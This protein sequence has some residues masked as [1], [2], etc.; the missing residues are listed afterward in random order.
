MKKYFII[1]FLVFV[2]TY[3]IIPHSVLA[4]VFPFTGPLVPCGT[5]STHPCTLCDIFVLLR[6]VINLFLTLIIFIAPILIIFGGIMLLTSAGRPEGISYGKRIITNA[7]I[8]IVLAFGAWVIINTVMVALVGENPK[9]GFP[10]PWNEIPCKSAG[11]PPVG[12]PTKGLWG[13]RPAPSGSENW[14]L[15]GIDS[16]Q[17]G[18]ASPQL[19]SFLNCMYDQYSQLGEK[20]TLMIT[21]ISSDILVKNPNCDTTGP[22]CGHHANSCHY[23]GTKCTGY[24][25]AVD[26]A[27]NVPCNV[28]QE[29]AQNCYPS[30]WINWEGNH[31]HVSVGHNNCGCNEAEKGNP[32]PS[33]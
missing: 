11:Q 4:G 10:W 26:F 16:K 27:A 17:K 2:F 19:A 9:K 7:I 14:V 21:S 1:A 29:L 31:T 25:Y 23:G 30:A 33:S 24:S 13:K 3:L 15:K 6:N 5:S 28:I 22:S 18:D 8:G 20:E 12:P 32:C